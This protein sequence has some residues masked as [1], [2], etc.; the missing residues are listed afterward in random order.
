MREKDSE[1]DREHPFPV[2]FIFLWV[3]FHA[4]GTHFA[5]W[6]PC[7]VFSGVFF[8]LAPGTHFVKQ[9]TFFVFSFMLFVGWVP[10]LQTKVH[11]SSLH[12]FFPHRPGARITKSSPYFHFFHFFFLHTRCPFCKMG[13]IFRGFF[14]TPGAYFMKQGPFFVFTLF[15][16]PVCRVPI[17]QNGVHFANWGP[18]FIFSLL[19]VCVCWV[20]IS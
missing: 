15:S 17:S 6:G 2:T 19:C 1:S 8:L 12:I 20:P 9:G 7:F 14:H 18:I 5:K 4:L 13:S 10:I 11:F 16:P 3:F